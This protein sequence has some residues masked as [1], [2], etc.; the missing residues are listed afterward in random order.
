MKNLK[1]MAI[2]TAASLSVA[3][4]CDK[5]EQAREWAGNLLKEK[6]IELEF[7][8]LTNLVE[9]RRQFEAEPEIWNASFDYLAAKCADLASL[10]EF[11]KFPI[12]GE[13][14]YANLSEYVPKEGTKLEGHRQYVDIQV[15]EGTVNWGICPVDDKDLEILSEFNPDKDCLFAKSPNMAVVKQTEPYIFVFFPEDLHMPSYAAEGEEYPDPLKKIVIK[16]KN[17]CQKN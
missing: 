1:T 13:D 11:G 15:S 14:C 6:N 7:H 16:V 12:I 17:T 9:L 2:I 10:E 8:P 5:T 3:S 4:C